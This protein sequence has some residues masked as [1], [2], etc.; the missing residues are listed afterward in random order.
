METSIH[1]ID[2]TI[3]ILSLLMAVGVGVYFSRKF[4]RGLLCCQWQCS[5]LGC[6]H[7]DV[8]HDYQ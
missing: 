8:C 4:N 3:V 6:R 2:M 7:V 1:W 5:C